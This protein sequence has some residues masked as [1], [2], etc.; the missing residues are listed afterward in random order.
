MQTRN[1]ILWLIPHTYKQPQTRNKA[2]SCLKQRVLSVIFTV[3]WHQADRYAN[4]QHYHKKEPFEFTGKQ[5]SLT[6]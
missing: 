5:D 6:G 4:K 3:V 1:T 2:A